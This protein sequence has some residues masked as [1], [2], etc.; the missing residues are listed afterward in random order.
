VPAGRYTHSIV[1]GRF[2][3]KAPVVRTVAKIRKATQID[4]V[5]RYFTNIPPRL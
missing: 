3:A 2:A 1:G 5:E 4:L